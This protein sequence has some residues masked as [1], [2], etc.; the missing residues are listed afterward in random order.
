MTVAS[1]IP[2]WRPPWA[3][4]P[5]QTQREYNASGRDQTLLKFYSSA[6]WKRFRA[7][8]RQTRVLCEHCSTQGRTTVGTHVHHKQDP[9]DAPDLALSAENVTLLC[10]ACHNAVHGQQGRRKR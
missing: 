5:K 10:L 2:T 3:K 4:T 8:I 7:M 6:P 9:R 1:R